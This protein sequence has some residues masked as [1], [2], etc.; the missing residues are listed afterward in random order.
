MRVLVA[1]ATGVIGLRGCVREV[2]DEEF[3]ARLLRPAVCSVGCGVTAVA[4]GDDGRDGSR[5]RARFGWGCDDGAS[6]Q[7]K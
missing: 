1:G 3:G 2:R 7:G 4:V 6:C 5:M